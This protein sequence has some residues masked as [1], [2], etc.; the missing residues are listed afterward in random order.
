M[1]PTILILGVLV[2]I[3]VAALLFR[4]WVPASRWG[5]VDREDVSE[6][7]FRD[8]ASA[9]GF[10]LT[11]VPTAD[12]ASVA[13]AWHERTVRIAYEWHF[14]RELDGGSGLYQ[15]PGEARTTIEL[16][17]RH[18]PPGFSVRDRNAA[19]VVV[20]GE[21]V[22]IADLGLDAAFIAEGPADFVSAL[23][24]RPEVGAA[25]RAL[26]A[27]GTLDVDSTR[28]SLVIPSL[29]VDASILGTVLD[30]AVRVEE[31][32]GADSAP[33]TPVPKVPRRLAARSPTPLRP[34]LSALIRGAQR[35]ADVR[36]AARA[37]EELASRPCVFEL[38][39]QRVTTATG[40]GDGVGTVTLHGLV[41]RGTSRVAARFP[42]ELGVLARAYGPGER[43]ACQGY[44]E[45]FD[46]LS[47]HVDVTCDM[48]PT[49]VG[50]VHVAALPADLPL[51]AVIGRLQASA[52]L[53]AS[54]LAGLIGRPHPASFHMTLV[55]P[56]NPY[57]IPASLHGGVTATGMIDDSAVAVDVR[58]P[59]GAP[60][61]PGATVTLTVAIAGWDDV[62]NRL[63]L[64]AVP[65][66]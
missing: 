52:G 9:L 25:L 64:D 8:M 15:R 7:R 6:G 50:G 20:G 37:A 1:D 51:S 59:Q 22:A 16:P 13:G 53:R 62:E 66:D 45:Y 2:G 47:D 40:V 12:R 19:D 42:G 29:L 4:Q 17:L 33:M 18:L 24:A 23:F 39:V 61:F 11:W 26:H 43:V 60:A 57:N 34:S 21:H 10:A 49:S 35:G 14:R 63:L 55:R 44:I 30:A 65:V 58:L 3:A 48:P 28:V 5:R 38:E 31:V 36:E 32:L 27:F 54:A 41:V 56:S 46:F